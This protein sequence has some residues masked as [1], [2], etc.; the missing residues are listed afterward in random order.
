MTC[1]STFVSGF[2]AAVAFIAFIFDIAFFYIAKARISK[3]GSAQIGIAI[4]L[5]LAAWVLLFFSGCF[6]TMGRCCISSRPRGG[7]GW[8][9]RKDN[10]EE[11]LRLDAVR[12]EAE[13]KAFQA[14]PE[15]G[16]PAFHEYQPLTARIDGDAVYLEPYK[17]GSLP[18][19]TQSGR[20][21]YAPAPQGTRAIDEYYTPSAKA[22]PSS[23]HSSRRRNSAT[24]ASSYPPTVPA[25][26]PPPQQAY[27]DG[28][29]STQSQT[30]GGHRHNASYSD[31]YNA[32]A[33]A[34]NHG[35]QASS[36]KYYHPSI[37]NYPFSSTVDST[38]PIHQQQP[39]SNS[40]HSQ[41]NDPYAPRHVQH[42]ASYHS[43]TNNTESY[44]PTPAIPPP[45]HR[46]YSL[47]GAG[48]S[49]S[50][51]LPEAHQ[52]Y[53]SPIVPPVNTNVGYVSP[54]VS[55]VRGP[56]APPSLAPPSEEAPPGYD[57][58]TAG[59]WAQ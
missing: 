26:S 19:S 1:C 12:A 6:Y 56:R 37:P 34:Y 43:A 3:I 22:Y 35:Q 10:N 58:E 36:C 21:G 16:L 54:I 59:H 17:D 28:Y 29:A 50:P 46:N 15:G 25:A 31:P 24:T 4:W 53:Q 55:P 14:K 51:R 27:L 40:N 18:S 45:P 41:Y 42:Q 5:T 23:Q 39:S 2:A 52:P 57:D 38:V 30:P 49:P 8:G 48:Y 33:Q 7:D 9:R 13:R 32:S 20:A 47:G 11:G 44:F